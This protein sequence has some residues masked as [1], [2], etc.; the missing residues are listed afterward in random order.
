MADFPS[1]LINPPIGVIHSLSMCS[2]GDLVV[3]RKQAFTTSTAWTTANRAIFIPFTT[4]VTVTAFQMAVENGATLGGNL[5]VGIYDINGTR[6][7]SSGTTAQAGISVMQT[8]NIADTVL[9]PGYYFMA[10]STDSTTAT[11]IGSPVVS[12]LGEFLRSLGVQEQ[13][14]AFVLPATATFANPASTTTT[15]PSLC[16]STR[17]VI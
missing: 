3:V 1:T 12:G 9:T 2:L 7:V 14:S 15:F 16:I 13:T 10:M 6:L 4:E 17:S 8:F 5:D 11:Y